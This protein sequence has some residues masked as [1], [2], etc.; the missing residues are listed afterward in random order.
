MYE[1]IDRC[2]SDQTTKQSVLPIQ[3]NPVVERVVG[4]SSRNKHN[5]K[6]KSLYSVIVDHCRIRVSYW[7]NGNTGYS[8]I[9]T[10]FFT[11][12][13][14]P[15]KMLHSSSQEGCQTTTRCTVNLKTGHISIHSTYSKQ[16][17]WKGGASTNPNCGVFL[18][19]VVAE[20]LL[21]KVFKNVQRMPQGNPGYD[22]ICGKGFKIDVKSTCLGNIRNNWGFHIRRNQEAEYFLCLA[23]DNRKDLNPKHIWLIPGRVL[24]HLTTASISKSTLD[25]WSEYELTD[26]LDDVLACCDTLKHHS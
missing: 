12:T 21:S 15:S 13:R 14:Q 19:V 6:T 23:F 5:K 16:K 26:K 18:G 22:F 2:R 24:N 1:K 7:I 20:R 9:Y 4:I 10:T 17:G 11:P 3:V 8:G 25:K